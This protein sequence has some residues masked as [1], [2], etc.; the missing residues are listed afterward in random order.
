MFDFQPNKCNNN[1]INTQREIKKVKKCIG[2]K[3]DCKK[4]ADKKS[5]DTCTFVL[6]YEIIK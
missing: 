1:T 2:G 4:Y 3:V 5:R 6:H